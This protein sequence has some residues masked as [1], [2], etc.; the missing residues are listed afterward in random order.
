MEQQMQTV[1]PIARRLPPDQRP[2]IPVKAMPFVLAG[3]LF[4]FCLASQAIG[5][6]PSPESIRIWH[7]RGAW[8][9][10]RTVNG[11]ITDCASDEHGDLVVTV[12]DSW[13]YL[14]E[15]RRAVTADAFRDLWLQLAGSGHVVMFY[16]PGLRSWTGD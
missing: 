1:Y 13:F 5:G 16:D 8:V 7:E 3:V 11:V 6:A 10:S 9:R 4:L 15:R 14:G 2:F 12:G